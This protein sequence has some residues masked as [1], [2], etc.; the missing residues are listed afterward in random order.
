MRK[1][2]EKIESCKDF[3]KFLGFE[4]N[5]KPC[6]KTSRNGYKTWMQSCYYLNNKVLLRGVENT[7]K[8]RAYTGVFSKHG[9]TSERNA[10]PAPRQR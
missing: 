2:G 4:S 8:K 3:P 5:I 10:L 1:I 6:R 9:V 7:A